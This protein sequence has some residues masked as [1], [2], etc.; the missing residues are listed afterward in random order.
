M[1]MRGLEPPSIVTAES[2]ERAAEIAWH[3]DEY[4]PGETVVFQ[5]EMTSYADP[6]VIEEIYE[7]GTTSG[8]GAFR[9]QDIQ[10]RPLPKT[11]A[12]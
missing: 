3:S 8:P 4:R 11:T 2:A 6:P 1:R 5:Q 10:I 7:A 12:A 9:N